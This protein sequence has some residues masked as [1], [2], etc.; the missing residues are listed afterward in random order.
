MPSWF[1]I[2]SFGFNTAE[3]EEGMLKSVR[4]INDVIDKEIKE[5]IP[6]NRII[7]GGFSQG[8]CMSLLT[9]LTGKRK[10]AGIAA[11]SGWLPLKEKFK[12][13]ASKDAPTVPVFWAHGEADPLVK[14]PFAKACSDSLM[15]EIGLPAAS[16]PTSPDGLSWH[17]YKGVGHTT[18]QD[19]LDD[20]REWIK[21]T[22][23]SEP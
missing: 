12:S 16:G 19:E 17:L 10:L 2:L 8:A 11:L 3:D 21:N 13:L 7:I 6:A 23:P 1:D 4:L 22:I 9:G 20:L 18:G 14:L 5:G 15:T